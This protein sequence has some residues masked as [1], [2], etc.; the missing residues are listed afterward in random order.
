MSV[1]W[2]RVRMS[3]RRWLEMVTKQV[4]TDKNQKLGYSSTTSFTRYD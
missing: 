4:L 1:F 3:G 2:D